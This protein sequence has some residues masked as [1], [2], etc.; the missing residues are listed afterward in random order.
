MLGEPLKRFSSSTPARLRLARALIIGLLGVLGLLLL[1][2]GL[3]VSG[4]WDTVHHRAAP[5]TTSAAG[6]DLALN[7]M[8]AQAVNT[9]LSSGD[10]GRGR[11]PVPHRKAVELY[12]TARRTVSRELRALAVAAEGDAAAERTVETLTENFAR[13]QELIG[14]SLENDGR[15]GGKTAARQDYEAAD[16]L[17]VT[18]LLPAAK[19]LLDTNNKAF[20]RE[21]DAARSRLTAERAAL[22]I[23]GVLLLALLVLLQVHLARHFGRVFNPGLLA[24]TAAA[25]VA[26]ALGT[27][28][29]GSG[30][31]ELRVARRDAFDSVVALS[32]AKALAY[33]ANADESRYLLLPDRRPAYERLFLDKSQRLYGIKSATL[34]TYDEQLAAT[35]AAYRA[36]HGDRRFTGEFRRELDNI[37]FVGEREAAERTVEAYAVYQ[38]DDRTVRALL[39]QGKER[40]AVAFCV[41]WEP[42]TSNAHFGAWMKE[43]DQVTDI[44]RAHFAQAVRDG[45]GALTGLLPAAGVALVLAALLTVLGLRPRLAEYR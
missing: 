35:W 44:N 16:E 3:A 30:S 10:A 13:Y 7:D 24:A 27:L 41:N 19:T 18:T 34:E 25:L 9:L 14:R 40:E 15:A 28:A 8:D 12:D 31:Q 4:T 23:T 29:L 2:S 22:L 26:V 5:R 38:R 1:T 6:L 36:D 39:R 17:L 37:T 21:Y 11:L 42:N 20:A 32:R 43:L 33:S 45:R